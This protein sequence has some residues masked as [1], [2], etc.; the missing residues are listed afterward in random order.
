MKKVNLTVKILACVMMPIV[1]LVIFATLAIS[2]VGTLMADELQED[3]LSTSNYAIQEVLKLVSQEDFSLQGEELY[4]GEVNLTTDTEWIDLFKEDADVDITIFVGNTRRAT[5]I[6]GSDGKRILG[7]KM[8]DEVYQKITKDGYYFSSS[9]LVE[10]VPYYGVYELMEDKEAGNEIITFTGISVEKSHS[11]YQGRLNQFIIF[12]VLI[13]V[14]FA[15]IAIVVVWVLVKSLHTTVSHLNEVADGRLD[16]SVNERL[17]SRGDEVGNIA[18]SIDSLMKKFVDI[19]NNLQESSTTLTDFTGDIQESFATINESIDNING[20]VGEIANGAMNQAN[21]IQEVTGQMNDM[22]AAVDKASGN[23]AN[24]KVSTESMEASNLEAGETLDE[25]VTISTNTRESIEVVQQ[26]TNDTNKSAMEIQ[27]VVALI[28]DIAGQTNLLSLNAS[29][30]AARAGE[31]GKGFA[32]VADEVRALAEQSRQSAEQIEAIV[33]ELLSKS[34]KNV[35]AMNVVM[36]EIE[37]QYDKLS[38]TKQVFEH[39][40]KEITNVSEAVEGIAGEIQ[41]INGSKDMVQ[42]N[43]ENLAAISEEN[44][45]STQETSA[46]MTQLSQIVSD[47]NDAVAKLQGISDSL[48]GDINEFTL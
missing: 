33:T 34:N 38:Q 3:H 22:G 29:I 42:G 7:T 21:E 41:N 17:I 32:V 31:Q 23:I 20:A 15:A 35:D 48:E 25:L 30:E 13:A 46:T 10:N 16:F 5:S 28:S 40:N 24:L 1:V 44:V 11:I 14:V 43:M 2:N 9:V 4:K 8:S 39:L 37:G 45:A 18:R 12:M 47:C 26:Q 36:K 19:V 27:N 6:V